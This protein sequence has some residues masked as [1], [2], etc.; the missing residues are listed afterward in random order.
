M[1]I[2]NTSVRPAAKISPVEP[3]LIAK[4]HDLD[5]ILFSLGDVVVA[6]SGGVDSAYLAAAAH[7]VLGSRSLA[8]TAVSPALARRER[9]DAADLAREIGFE[10]V[11]VSTSE[12]ERS[13]YVRNSGD[14]CYWCKVELLE[15]LGP[16]AER[17]GAAIALGTNADDPDDYRPGLRAA[18]EGGAV[19]PLLQAGLAKDEIRA[20]A[21]A[22]GIRVADKPATPCLAS[23]I[24]YGVEV[25]EAR[26]SRIDAAEEALRKL[27]FSILRVRDHGDR[28]R[29]EVREEDVPRA[30][31]LR[32][33]IAEA[34][35]NEGF[36]EVSI[37]PAGYRAGSMN[38][39][40]R[41]PSIR[42]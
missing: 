42:G 38:A 31:E 1:C 2:G 11:E 26:L 39:L 18:R 22:E 20:L 16:I 5:N 3:H 27:G 4:R 37:D 34:L 10:A 7:R 35:R 36:R 28:A 29:V 13:Q 15:V 24:A 9:A 8:V 17:R 40:L 25:T 30:F 33:S 21:K 19:A 12:L 41:P 23:R 6:Y 14:R 32:S